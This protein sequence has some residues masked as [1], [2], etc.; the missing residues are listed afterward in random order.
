MRLPKLNEIAVAVA[1]D[2]GGVGPHAEGL[3]RAHL[4]KLKVIAMAVAVA[5]RVGRVVVLVELVELP[6]LVLPLEQQRLGEQQHG[7]RHDGDEDQECLQGPLP[8]QQLALH[9]HTARGRFNTP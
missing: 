3:V 1:A 8:G 6:A 9:R 7:D 4:A 5:G 2:G